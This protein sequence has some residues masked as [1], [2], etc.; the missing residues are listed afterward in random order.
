MDFGAKLHGSE[1]RM[2][3]PPTY[4]GSFDRCYVGQYKPRA[5]A[6]MDE[7]EKTPKNITTNCVK[8]MTR[9]KVMA[10]KLAPTVFK[11]SGIPADGSARERLFDVKALRM[12]LRIGVN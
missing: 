11:T 5:K 2:V 12:A 8:N 1:I 4:N 6:L 9:S 7:P 3:P 10:G